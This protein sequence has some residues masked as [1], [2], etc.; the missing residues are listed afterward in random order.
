VQYTLPT[1]Q[2]LVLLRL[3]PLYVALVISSAIVE[4]KN[5]LH[6]EHFQN[7]ANNYIIFR[8]DLNLQ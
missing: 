1:A 6:E 4:E 5:E 7:F 3:P 8:G 2:P